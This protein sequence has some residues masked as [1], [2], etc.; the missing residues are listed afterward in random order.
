VSGARELAV[1]TPF[2][3]ARLANPAVA[4]LRAYDP[5]HDLPA[6]RHRFGNA[7]AEL[8]SNENPL[9]PGQRALAAIRAA[10]PEVYRYPDPRGAALKRA[11]AAHLGV[12]P[13]RIALGNG[14]HELLMLLAQCFAAPDRS[15]VR[16]QYGFAVF[17]IA[18]VATGARAV[19]V[20]ALPREHPTAPFGHD[21]AAMANAVRDDTCLVYL[22]NPNNPTGT[23]FDDAALAAFMAGI[24][25]DV[26]V[27]ADEAYH[28]YVDV[29][30]LAGG[31]GLAARHP[32]LVVTRTFSKAFGLAGLRVGY[33]VAH[34]SVV[35][36]LERLRESFNVNALA[37]AA[38]EAALGDREHLRRVRDFNCSER[39][40]LRDR[41]HERG[42]ACL[43]S[44]TNFLLVDL[45]HEAADLE[46]R[47]RERGVVVRPMGGYGLP[48]TLR[49]SVGSRPENERLV[50]SLDA[51]AAGPVAAQ[52]TAVRADGPGRRR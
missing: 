48:Q 25:D 11:L 23:W 28:E 51:C 5:G 20:A 19:C 39:A 24:R 10:A 43:P 18:T 6:L 45:G 33:L 12:V 52:A 36:V 46:R 35:A 38:A 9:G 17:G 40:W 4:R 16:S 44:Q 1:S 3:A 30:G 42:L 37:L 50:A 15:I 47:L 49:I 41:L 21:L 8:G 14:S 32:N 7:I 34:E 13:G 26:L 22:A 2:D 29:P 27:V 31:L